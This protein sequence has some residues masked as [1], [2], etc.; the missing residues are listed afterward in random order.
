VLEA[1]AHPYTRALLASVPPPTHRTRGQKRVKLATIEGALPDLR[2]PPPG[3][4]FQARCPEV[5]DRCR[6]E[7]PTFVPGEGGTE[8]RC[9]A[10]EER[11]GAA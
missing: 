3:C 2:S 11:R 9:F 8:A 10:V 6:V 7:T 1:P 5:M 4:R